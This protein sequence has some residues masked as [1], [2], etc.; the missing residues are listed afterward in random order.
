MFI[1]YL[2]VAAGVGYYIYTKYIAPAENDPT[3]SKTD[4][5]RASKTPKAAAAVTSSSSSR[6]VAPWETTSASP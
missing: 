1:I 5:I 4:P 6:T 2:L 3:T